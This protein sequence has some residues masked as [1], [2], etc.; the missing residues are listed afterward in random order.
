MRKKGKAD[1]GGATG[2]LPLKGPGVERPS[3][4]ELDEALEDYKVKRDARCAAT[5]EEVPAKDLV[6]SLFHKHAEALQ[7]GKGT[8]RY[9]FQ[10][11]DEIKDVYIEA[12]KEKVKFGK[13]DKTEE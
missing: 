1:K 7:D 2:S 3:I 4:P 5:K 12:A 10:D 13:H 9:P 6:L 8:L 11:G